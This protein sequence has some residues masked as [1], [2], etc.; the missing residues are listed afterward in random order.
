MASWR[1][2]IH[3]DLGNS[4]P[5]SHK[6][7]C[8]EPH[9]LPQPPAESTRIPQ[10]RE[11]LKRLRKCLLT[12]LLSVAKVTSHSESPPLGLQTVSAPELCPGTG[13]SLLCLPSQFRVCHHPALMGFY[14]TVG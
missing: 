1:Q 6:I 11:S 9:N 7:H 2:V 12:R 8:L 4:L 5:A 10:C 14:I 13:V 3:I